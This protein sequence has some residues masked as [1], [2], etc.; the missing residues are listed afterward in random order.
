MGDIFLNLVCAFPESLHHTNYGDL[1]YDFFSSQYLFVPI[2]IF[3][4]LTH[5]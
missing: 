5:F 2:L 1:P 4:V 3:E